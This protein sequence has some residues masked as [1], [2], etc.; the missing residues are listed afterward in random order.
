MTA[1]AAANLGTRPWWLI[2][3]DEDLPPA[4]GE[5]FR[6]LLAQHWSNSIP[7]GYAAV[8]ET[9]V[10]GMRSGG[11]FS[12]WRLDWL[13][14]GEI[15]RA[16]DRLTNRKRSTREPAVRRLRSPASVTP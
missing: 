4:I 6:R 10:R 14:T 7:E 5:A 8:G 12:P 13:V 16:D 9:K 11:E 2:V 1:K 3:N 15:R